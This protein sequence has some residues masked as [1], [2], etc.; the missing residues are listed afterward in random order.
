MFWSS[1]FWISLL[2][3]SSWWFSLP[4]LSLCLLCHGYLHYHH[5]HQT[6]EPKVCI[7][8]LNPDLDILCP[9]L[10]AWIR[11]LRPC[12][13]FDTTPGTKYFT[14]VLMVITAIKSL[15]FC[16]ASCLNLYTTFNFVASPHLRPPPVPRRIVSWTWWLGKPS[17]LPDIDEDWQQGELVCSAVCR[18]TCLSGQVQLKGE[19][20]VLYV[21]KIAFTAPTLGHFY[22]YSLVC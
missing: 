3:L 20:V 13:C 2:W 8:C 22:S 15:F 21:F 16:L 12:I 4:L 17:D 18:R 10:E 7:I 5:H 9:L 6:R 1:F 19:E 14:G 11:L